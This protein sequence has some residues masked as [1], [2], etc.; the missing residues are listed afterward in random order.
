[1]DP[2]VEEMDFWQK[3]YL[4]ALSHPDKEYWTIAGSSHCWTRLSA[5]QVADFA[6]QDFRAS[7]PPSNH[8]YPYR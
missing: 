5:K 3:A 2:T 6:L 4:I 7:F 1:M 8:P